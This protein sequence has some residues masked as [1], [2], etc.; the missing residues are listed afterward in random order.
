[1]VACRQMCLRPKLLPLDRGYMH[2]SSW[3]QRCGEICMCKEKKWAKAEEAIYASLALGPA[4]RYV[5]LVMAALS[6]MLLI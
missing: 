6:L 2:P 4:P 1:M 3:R 5:T